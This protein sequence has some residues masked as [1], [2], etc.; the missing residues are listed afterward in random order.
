MVGSPIIILK[1]HR[2]LQSANSTKVL[3]GTLAYALGFVTDY[4]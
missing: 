1:C 4:A 2:H 3:D